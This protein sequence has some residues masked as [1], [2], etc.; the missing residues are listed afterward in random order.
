MGNNIKFRP[1]TGE[2]L[3]FRQDRAPFTEMKYGKYPAS[4]KACGVIAAYNALQLRG[5]RG[6]E[7]SFSR[8][9]Q[10]FE[11]LGY[12]RWKGLLG[13]RAANIG[14]YMKWRGIPAQRWHRSGK[15]LDRETKPGAVILVCVWNGGRLWKG[16][17][18][19]AAVRTD[20]GWDAYNR[21]YC[22]RAL[23]YPTFRQLLQKDTRQYLLVLQ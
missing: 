22:D 15:A 7:N 1:E 12:P 16:M 4:E 8:V 11:M 21:Y 3:I 2:G 9:L 6:Q 20:S 19:F 5:Y 10:D 17:H 13:T 23:S 18:L 14:R